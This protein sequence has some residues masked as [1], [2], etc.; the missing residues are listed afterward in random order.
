MNGYTSG[1]LFEPHTLSFN[2]KVYAES[3]VVFGGNKQSWLGVND[4]GGSWV[5]AS[6]GTDI[7]GKYLVF[8]SSCSVKMR[9]SSAFSV[10]ILFEENVFI[11]QF[12]DDEIQL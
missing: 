8:V 1:R 4:K 3:V 11:F 2:D 5:Y 7:G 6:S 9:G 10:C 12:L